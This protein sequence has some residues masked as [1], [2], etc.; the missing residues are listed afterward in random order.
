MAVVE[1][2]QAQGRVPVTVFH[3]QD[4]I[5]LGNAAEMEKAAR[6]AFENGT[7]DM[8]IDLT[9]TPS[10]TS[11]G[12]RSLVVIY[13]MFSADGVKHVKLAGVSEQIR[14]IFEIAG[15]TRNVE[16]FDTVDDAVAS[17]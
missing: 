4:R 15:I 16:I 13:K 5:N 12:I 1:T 3:L 10:I 2:S 6:I 9:K 17:F 7:Q 11:A 8:V 14:E